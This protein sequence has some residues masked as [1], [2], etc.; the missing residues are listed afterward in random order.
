MRRFKDSKIQGFARDFE[1]FFLDYQG[2]LLVTHEYNK[3]L[4]MKI[5]SYHD[6]GRLET[7][8]FKIY[9]QS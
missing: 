3:K 1:K 7:F 2:G 4:N 8:A 9:F 6:F 5:F